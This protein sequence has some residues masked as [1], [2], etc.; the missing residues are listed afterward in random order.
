DLSRTSLSLSDQE[1]SIHWAIPL[2]SR[3]AEALLRSPEVS[4]MLA[5][6]LELV[7]ESLPAER[8]CVF[9]FDEKTGDKTLTVMRQKKGREGEIF[10]V[11]N[12]VIRKAMADRS[13]VLVPNSLGDEHYG[14]QQSIVLNQIRS[15]MC[16]PLIHEDGVIGIIYLD[17]QSFTE[18]FGLQHLE[19]LTALAV[20]AGVA[21]QQGQLRARIQ[22]ERDIRQRLARYSAP[23]VVERIVSETDRSASMIAEEREVTVLFLDLV[24]FTTVSEQLA[25]AEVTR[26]LNEVF[27]NLTDCVFRFEGTLD[28]FTGDG[29]MAIFGA[30]LDQ[31]D[32]AER[33]VRAGLAMQQRIQQLDRRFDQVELRARIGINSGPVLAGDIGSP[34]RKDYT[35]IGDV[36]NIASRLESQVARPGDII[37]GA[38]TH[39]ALPSEFRCDDIGEVQIKGKQKSVSV[40]R[41]LPEDR[42][43][44]DTPSD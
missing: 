28:K 20:L 22:Q 2:F 17:T 11:S 41:V 35:V 5:T 34:R 13:S 6:I 15:V 40:Y 8:G 23:S 18:P 33:A 39:D 29:L 3:A 36:V 24:Q 44:T 7:F 21:V 10:E 43:P 37:I 42:G 26:V 16:A 14:S 30:P 27:E 32:H 9:L 1:G 19:V 25:P 38:A 4:D 31:A 12:S